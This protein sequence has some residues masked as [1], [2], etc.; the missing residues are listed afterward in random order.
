MRSVELT[1]QYRGRGGLQNKS[2]ALSTHTRKS[3]R[4]GEGEKAP[5]KLVLKKIDKTYRIPD[6]SEPLERRFSN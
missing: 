5:G 1:A 3:A 6:T 4:K 2:L